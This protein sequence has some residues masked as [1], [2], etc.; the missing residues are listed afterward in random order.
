MNSRVRF[1]ALS[2]AVFGLLAVPA[3]RGATTLGQIGGSGACGSAGYSEI[4]VSTG[5]SPTYVVPADGTITSWSAAGNSDTDDVLMLKIFRR[6]STP[7]SYLVVGQST[8]Q[9]LAANVDNGP[10]PT[11]IAVRAG[12]L[13]GVKMVAGSA[14]PCIFNT[15]TTGDTVQEVLPDNSGVGDVVTAT[16]QFNVRRA[17]ISAT[18]EPPPAPS[19]TG[20]R[21]AALRKCKKKKSASARR[22]CRKRARKLPV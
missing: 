17:N 6:T 21:A 20:Q 1:A 11:S 4:Q 16:G 5:A 19:A 8:P 18:W 13:L 22:K 2:V 15:G 9:A 3:A 12:D 7:D 14:P 10:F